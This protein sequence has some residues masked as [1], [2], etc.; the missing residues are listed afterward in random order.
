METVGM[1]GSFGHKRQDPVRLSHP[2]QGRPTIRSR[3]SRSATMLSSMTSSEASIV[4]L[5]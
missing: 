4:L 5:P 2:R 1:R 3:N